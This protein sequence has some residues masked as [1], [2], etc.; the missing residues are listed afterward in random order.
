MLHSHSVEILGN[1]LSPKVRKHSVKSTYSVLI[2]LFSALTLGVEITATQ[3]LREIK[4]GHFEVPTTAILTILAVLN[5]NF[6]F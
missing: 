4:F 1:S 5:L 3:I 6:Y 2:L